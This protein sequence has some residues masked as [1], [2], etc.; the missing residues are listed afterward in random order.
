MNCLIGLLVL[1]VLGLYVWSIPRQI[2]ER[3]NRLLQGIPKKGVVLGKG[4][5]PKNPPRRSDAPPS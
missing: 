3:T 4:S 1:T 2:E 5:V